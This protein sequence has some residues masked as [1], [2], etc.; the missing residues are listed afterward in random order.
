MEIVF[1]CLLV[2]CTVFTFDFL[3]GRLQKFFLYRRRQG[4][5]QHETYFRSLISS[6]IRYFNKVDLETQHKWLFRTYLF[7]RSKKFHYVG[8]EKTDEMPIL[9]SATAAQ[10]TLG[11]ENFSLNY[12]HDIYVLQHDYHYG[13]YSLPFMGHVDSSGIYLSWDNFL[14]GIRSAHDSSNVGLHEMAHALAY[15]N[16][17]TKT[18]ED[19]H[20][21][22]EFHQ[23]SKVARPVYQDMQRGRKTILGDYAATNYHEFW[24]VSVEVF[25]ENPVRM[26]HELPELYAAMARLL[27]QDPHKVLV[28]SLAAA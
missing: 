6:N 5:E 1:I 17:I 7:Y 10:L 19:K 16:F 23:Y 20:F 18:D 15:V 25:F 28:T 8:V 22:K 26:R 2:F 14:Q 9:I 13:Y 12:F 4:F 24:A 21:K 11:L 3:H 27:K